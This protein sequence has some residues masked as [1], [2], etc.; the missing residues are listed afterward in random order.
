MPSAHTKKGVLWP[1]L[2]LRLSANTH[3]YTHSCLRFDPLPGRYA[4]GLRLAPSLSIIKGPPPPSPPPTLLLHLQ[5]P[6]Q[7]GRRG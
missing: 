2:V 5:E 4:A 7:R 3:S 1:Y 6:V